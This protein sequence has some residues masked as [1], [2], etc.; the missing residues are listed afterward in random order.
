M[1]NILIS[2]NREQ[3]RQF[4]FLK[5][6][7][8]SINVLST[9]S[10]LT[11]QIEEMTPEVVAVDLSMTEAE[12]TIRFL[13]Q[14]FPQLKIL[15][16]NAPDKALILEAL[17]RGASGSTRA[18][19]TEEELQ[20]V[21]Q[22][23]EQDCVLFDSKRASNPHFLVLPRGQI[24]EK[25]ETWQYW[26]GIEILNYWRGEPFPFQMSL[27]ACW[28]EL[29]VKDLVLHLNKSTGK[30][31]IRKELDRVFESLCFK[32]H[33]EATLGH[34][35]QYIEDSLSNWYFNENF[36]AVNG[37]P[38]CCLAIIRD[39][40]RKFKK[41]SVFKLQKLLKLWSKG[42]SYTLSQWLEEVVSHLKRKEVEFE[43]TRQSALTRASS[44]RSAYQNLA[45]KLWSG[46]Q[47]P[48]F[49]S[50]LRALIIQYHDIILAEISGAASQI[51]GELLDELYSCRERVIATDNLLYRCQEELE[52][53]M[54]EGLG[55]SCLP[56]R[57]WSE[58]EVK[59]LALRSIRSDL[60]RKLGKSLNSWGNSPQ[61]KRQTIQDEVLKF[62]RNLALKLILE[63][64]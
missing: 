6:E 1:V 17:A 32:K 39:N 55:D 25:L 4:S 60:E 53:K 14:N 20:L 40:A 34:K 54:N 63:Q 10:A 27:D 48:D 37:T 35:L 59:R 28:Q 7:L 26:V 8:K 9:E 21:L 33:Q 52:A 38:Q 57:G 12:D 43:K 15:A 13:T 46:Q 49:D 42:G 56:E 58:V 41:V 16:I 45:E 36:T 64:Y 29:G 2:E 18:E 50:A 24:A 51:I 22:S 47:L 3:E 19:I 30:L 5:P 44:V 11:A 61:I 31:P 62:S 23:L